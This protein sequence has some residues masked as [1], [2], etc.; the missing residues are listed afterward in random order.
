MKAIIGAVVSCALSALPQFASS[1]MMLPAPTIG[2]QVTP[3]ATVGTNDVLEAYDKPRTGLL[4]SFTADRVE[5]APNVSY[6]VSQTLNHRSVFG[7]ESWI[8]LSPLEID[9]T[10]SGNRYWIKLRPG[11]SALL[12]PD[13]TAMQP[14]NEWPGG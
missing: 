9:G 12:Q 11:V 6:I 4:S 14:S 7:S 3:S 8:A 10:I 1:E 13:A 2:Q 5:I